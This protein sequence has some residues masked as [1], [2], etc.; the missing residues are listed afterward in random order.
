MFSGRLFGLED[1]SCTLQAA[2]HTE[3]LGQELLTLGNPQ[4]VELLSL[5]RWPCLWA[6]CNVLASRQKKEPPDTLLGDD[7]RA[8]F[9][10]AF[11]SAELLKEPLLARMGG[12]QLKREAPLTQISTNPPPQLCHCKSRFALLDVCLHCRL[13][14]R[15]SP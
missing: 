14:S 5:H 15:Y 10:P 11:S 8:K 4:L 9:F 3:A 1:T 7:N 13:T 6:L 12:L 2:I